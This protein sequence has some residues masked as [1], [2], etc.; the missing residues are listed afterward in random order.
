MSRRN[1]IEQAAPGERPSAI[2]RSRPCDPC[3][4]QLGPFHTPIDPAVRCRHNSQP[5]PPAPDPDITEPIHQP[6][7]WSVP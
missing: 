1:A 5:P 6:E 3:G 2:R 7:P 4:W